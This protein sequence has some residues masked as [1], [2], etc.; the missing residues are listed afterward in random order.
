MIITL[1]PEI[2]D[3]ERGAVEAIL[4]SAG[5]RTAPVSTHAGRYMVATG[6]PDIDLRRIG[7]MPG[8]MDVHR[9]SDSYKLVSRKWKVRPTLIDL[10]DGVSVHE[11]SFQFAAGPCSIESESVTALTVDF[12]RDNGVRIVRGGAFKPR[13][14]PYSFMGGGLDALKSLHAYTEPG[15]M[16]VISEVLEI[17]QIE[18]MYPY[19]DIFQ[20]G[21]RNSQ[22]FNL[23][24]EL[25]GMDKPVL[26]KRSMS[27][28]LDELLQSAEYV[29]SNG[30]E[31]ILLCE[32]GIRSFETAS[33]NTLDINAIPILKEKSHLPVLVDPSH[34]MGIR[35]FIEP[36]ALAAIIAG[37]DGLL[38]EV[39]PEP[40]KAVSDGDQTLNFNEAA[41]LFEKGRELVKWRSA[42]SSNSSI[43]SLASSAGAAA[44]SS[45]VKS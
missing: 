19:V 6:A 39:H 42:Y 22:N 1:R 29:F 31:K 14:S 8:V 37:A 28:T 40:E 38:V 12:L 33:R 20:V 2:S 23:L 24:R 7:H 25:G 18:D 3:D 13:T 11:E 35:R 16:K 36:V 32:R 34:G 4:E 45:A 15:K 10:G 27:G 26:I 9:V 44:L 21:T 30:N 43:S 41:S 5:Y 17:S